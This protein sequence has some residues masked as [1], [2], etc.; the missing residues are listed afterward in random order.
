MSEVFGHARDMAGPNSL[1]YA[2]W[3]RPLSDVP[4]HF[5]NLQKNRITVQDDGFNYTIVF[6]DQVCN[7]SIFISSDS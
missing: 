7:S 3:M 6:N 4:P 1:D 5:V 2:F